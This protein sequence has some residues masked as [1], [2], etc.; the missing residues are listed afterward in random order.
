MATAA[1]TAGIQLRFARRRSDLGSATCGLRADELGGPIVVVCGLVGGAGT[2]TLAYF[3]ARQAARESKVPALVAELDLSGG[4]GL[5]ALTG[6]ATPHGLSALASR[7]ADDD[8]PEHAFGE[9]EPRLRLVAGPPRREARAEDVDLEALLQDAR[10]AHGLVVVD[11]AVAG[12]LPAWLAQKAGLVIWTTAAAPCA[13]AQTEQ[14]LRGDQL[15]PAGRA[16]EVMV[17]TALQPEARARVRDLRG[18]ARHRC[19]RLVLVGHARELAR[20]DLRSTPP[21]MTRALTA[22]AP[23]LRRHR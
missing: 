8:P 15:V 14:L 12:Q 18:L 23:E 2:T 21:A 11:C 1:L 6:A 9:L 16:P 7:V 10:A 20:N 4:G 17:A 22:L 13:M 5:A 19:T 3:L